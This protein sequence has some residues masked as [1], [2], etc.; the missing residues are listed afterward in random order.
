MAQIQQFLEAVSRNHTNGRTQ[1]KMSRASTEAL[2]AVVRIEQ[3]S[4]EADLGPQGSYVRRL[5]HQIAAEHGM[6]SASS[7]REPKRYVTISG[8]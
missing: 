5:Q 3:G 2:E 1:G 4:G 8:S 6:R 7:G